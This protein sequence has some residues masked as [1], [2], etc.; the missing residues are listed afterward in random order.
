MNKFSKVIGHTRDTQKAVV[1]LYTSNEQFKNE[2][3]ENPIYN[4]IKKKNYK[5]K[6]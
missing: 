3:K 4:S 5:R 1:F 2:I 6:K